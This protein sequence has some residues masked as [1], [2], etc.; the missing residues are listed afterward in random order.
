[1]K[2]LTVDENLESFPRVEGFDEPAPKD[3]IM[4]QAVAGRSNK[5]KVGARRDPA[6]FT[7]LLAASKRKE[8][9]QNG[10]ENGSEAEVG[11]SKKQN[12]M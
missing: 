12:M 7:P 3:V 5:R 1:M 2:T 6:N 10:K 4:K 8:P 9:K 11:K